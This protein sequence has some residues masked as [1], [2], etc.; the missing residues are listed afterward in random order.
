LIRVVVSQLRQCVADDIG[1]TKPFGPVPP[2]GSL[3]RSTSRRNNDFPA[4]LG[5]GECFA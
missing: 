2:V 4:P 5:G 3:S 1:G